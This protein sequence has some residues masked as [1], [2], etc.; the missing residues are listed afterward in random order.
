MFP[1]IRWHQ[2]E[3]GSPQEPVQEQNAYHI[4]T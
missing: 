4:M 1:G 2:G 3:K